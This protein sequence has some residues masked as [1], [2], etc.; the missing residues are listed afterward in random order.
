MSDPT[1]GGSA[2]VPEGVRT[3]PGA[4]HPGAVTR[5]VLVRHGESA[6][7]VAGVIGGPRGCTG[8]SGQGRLQAARLRD[9]L[10]ATGEARTAVALYSSPLARA[11]ETAEAIAPGVGDGS[12]AVIEDC[13]LCEL[14]PGEADGL[15]WEE[16]SRRY[17]VPDFEADPDMEVAPGGESW[18]GFVA[19]ASAALEHLATRHPGGL[20]VVACHAGVVESAFLEFLPIDTATRRLRLPTAN[21]SITEFERDPDRWRLVR[22]NDSTHLA[23]GAFAPPSRQGAV[24]GGLIQASG[25]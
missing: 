9:R 19:R 7:S 6:C 10:M 21:T 18:S 13:G 11:R 4:G 25:D 23:P 16:Y 17:Q 24:S 22:Y 1:A 2:P 14:H 8:L 20:V 12:L 5:L 3:L 15:R